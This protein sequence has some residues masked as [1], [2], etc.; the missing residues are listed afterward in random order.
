M[1]GQDVEKNDLEEVKL[2]MQING[3]TREII[4]IKKDLSEEELNAMVV[5]NQ[6]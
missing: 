2:A 3:K 6:K 4:T 1:N 5:K